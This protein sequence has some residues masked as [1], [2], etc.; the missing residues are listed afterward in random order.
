[1]F[2]INIGRDARYLVFQQINKYLN[3]FYQILSL[4]SFID[5]ETFSLKHRKF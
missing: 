1:M 4:V 3:D 2:R 5:H